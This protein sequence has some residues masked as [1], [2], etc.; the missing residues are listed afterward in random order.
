MSV[1]RLRGVSAPAGVLWVALLLLSVFPHNVSAVLS[2]A[3]ISGPVL[4]IICALIRAFF[5][6]AGAV[7]ALVFVYAGVLWIISQDDP[8]KRKQALV[9]MT[10]AII[11]L[12]IIGAAN[13]IVIA[14][15]RRFNLITVIC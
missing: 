15:A 9:T 2:F 4:N 14:L 8:G 13:T 1:R 6:V 11:G 12:I 5:I 3:V 10:H 7:C